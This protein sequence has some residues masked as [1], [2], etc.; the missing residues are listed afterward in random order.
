[1]IIVVVRDMTAYLPATQS[2]ATEDAEEDGEQGMVVHV[3]TTNHCLLTR[4]REYEEGE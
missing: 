3:L 4:G 2:T 1:M